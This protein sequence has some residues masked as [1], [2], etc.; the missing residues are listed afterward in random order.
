[1]VD[2]NQSIL[3]VEDDIDVAEML[4]AYFRVQGYDV[5]TVNLGGDA[6]TTCRNNRPDLILLDIRLP[7]INGFEVAK[8]LRDARRTADVPIIFLTEKRG[9]LDILQ[10]LELGADDYIT[11]PFDIQELRLRVRNVLNRLNQRT[12]NNPITN[13]PEGILVDE[14][15]ETCFQKKDWALLLISL[16]NMDTFRDVYGFVAS[17]DALRASS[18]M[19]LNAVRDVGSTTDF[20]GHLGLYDFVVVTKPSVIGVLH[21]RIGSYLEQTSTY[22][23]PLDDRSDEHNQS[24]TQLAFRFNIKEPSD[25]PF[26]N[27]EFL[28]KRLLSS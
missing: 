18:M 3:I 6:V 21:E 5:T 26:Q 16:G 24:E 8:Q 20:V 27:F 17:D 25:G 12:I 19:I 11:K 7:D 14:H 22:F 15:L 13:L 10:G 2:I 28:K 23:Y 9:R 4:G 1:M